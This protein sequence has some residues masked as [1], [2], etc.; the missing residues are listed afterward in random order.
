MDD[1]SQQDLDEVI[2]VIRSA[3]D[4]LALRLEE[5]G[6]IGAAI[7]FAMFEAFSDRMID[8]E[9]ESAWRDVLTAALDEPIET[10]TVH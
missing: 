2:E 10:Q 4:E 3:L 8:R 1:E 7:D 5:E 6:V 9:G